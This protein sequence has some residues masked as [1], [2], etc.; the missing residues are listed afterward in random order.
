[1][2][3]VKKDLQAVSKTLKQLTKKTERIA[4][5]LAKLEKA[6]PTR[7]SKPKATR[8]LKPKATRKLKLR[9]TRKLKPKARPKAIKKSPRVSSSGTVLAIIESSRKGIDVTTLRKKSGLEGRKIND[10]VHRLKKEG[11][12]K[13]S[14]RGVY[15]KA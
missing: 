15:V 8:K 5:K 4:K 13:T 14:G 9:A 10:I 6:K 1:M 12:I 11:K 2:K 7:K 3:Q